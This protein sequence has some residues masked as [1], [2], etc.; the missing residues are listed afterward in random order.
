[1]GMFD[2]VQVEVPLPDGATPDDFREPFDMG[3]STFQTKDMDCG[4]GNYRITEDGLFY[5]GFDIEAKYDD[6]GEFLGFERHDDEWGLTDY[7]G[8]LTFYSSD[9]HS[10]WHQYIAYFDK[11]KLIKISLDVEAMDY[12]NSR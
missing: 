4:L 12:F 9:K 10:Q 11:G 1:M 8:P 2:W 6:E 3:D 7:T 5:L